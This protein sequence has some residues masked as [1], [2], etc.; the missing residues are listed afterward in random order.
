M[1]RLVNRR[2][3]LTVA[4]VIGLL[5]VVLLRN[6][7]WSLP[8]VADWTRSRPVPASSGP[9]DAI[10]SMLDAQRAGDTTAYLEAF[11]GPIRDQL[12]QVVKEDSA[13]KFASYLMR[14]ADFKG[15]AVT[16]VDRQSAED[17]LVRVEYIYNDRNEVQQLRLKRDGRHWT[18]VQVAGAEQ[19][20]SLLP[21]DS[22]VAD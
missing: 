6:N 1:K 16:V 18:I 22:P 2:V 4:F 7:G 14:N 12:Q 13:S 9:E 21:F 5:V 8:R 20:K 10:Y 3:V 11:S 15:V 17:A 19:I